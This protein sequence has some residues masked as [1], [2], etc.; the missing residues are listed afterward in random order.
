MH[1]PSLARLGASIVGG[2]A[3]LALSATIAAAQGA[4]QP[5]P[6]ATA[7]TP[8]AKTADGTLAPA[9][10]TVKFAVDSVP[11]SASPVV[12]NA[13]LSSAIGEG[14]AASFPAESA[15]NVVAVGPAAAG[16]A[17]ALQLTLNTSAAKTGEYTVALK[18]KT[19]ECS[20]KL[21]IVAG[22]K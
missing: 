14:V 12:I 13:S 16:G 11:S 19:G 21:K 2:F 15:V 1:Q 9:A 22:G 18:G 20:G 10:C 17:N 7:P 6:P 4:T 3:T 8:A 5:T